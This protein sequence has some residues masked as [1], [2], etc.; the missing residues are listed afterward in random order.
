VHAF[1]EVTFKE[2]NRLKHRKAKLL[3]YYIKSWRTR[4][5]LHANI[6]VVP[7][8]LCTICLQPCRNIANTSYPKVGHHQHTYIT[9]C[10]AV[11]FRNWNANV[12]V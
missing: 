7:R 12:I 10:G 6:S 2:V 11:W 1:K 4:L 9:N 3:R 5:P 8:T